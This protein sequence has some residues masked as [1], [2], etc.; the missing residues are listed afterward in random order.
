V[1]GLTELTSQQ[2]H[3]IDL[4]LLGHD[5]ATAAARAGVSAGTVS[6]WRRHHPAFVAKLNQRR[7]ELWGSAGD[8]LR[9]LLDEA[10]NV[11]GEQMRDT[12]EP[13]RFRAAKTLLTLAGGRDLFSCP[14]PIPPKDAPT[15]SPASD[16]ANL[17]P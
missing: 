4:L 10:V 16:A 6:R 13:T 7:A 12:W 14:P 2:L 17:T 1:E 3:V 11:L 9:A 8:R 15:S 5:G